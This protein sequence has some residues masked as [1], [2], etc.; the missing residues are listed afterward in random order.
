L[1]TAEAGKGSAVNDGGFPML[2]IS[3]FVAILASTGTTAIGV[4]AAQS[5][6]SGASKTKGLGRLL[7]RRHSSDDVGFRKRQI[8]SGM[9]RLTIWM[10]PMLQVMGGFSQT[11]PADVL[12]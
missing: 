9:S 3:A 8:A 1:G 5:Q 12:L 11:E 7:A 10:V 6:S 4:S 2:R